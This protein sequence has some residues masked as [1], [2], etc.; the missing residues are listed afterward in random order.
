MF[1]QLRRRFL[2]ISLGFVVALLMPVL[3]WAA[4]SPWKTAA[5]SASKFSLSR[6]AWTVGDGYELL[7]PSLV[8]IPAPS[9][10]V[11][12]TL[13]VTGKLEL[14]ALPDGVSASECNV[15]GDL[16]PTATSG[17]WLP[18]SVYL[19]DRP[20]ASRD[21]PPEAWGTTWPFVGEV[22]LL[23]SSGWVDYS[24]RAFANCYSGGGEEGNLLDGRTLAVSSFTIRVVTVN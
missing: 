1:S 5:V 15:G 13:Y 2:P 20:G 23:P 19:F 11:A 4:S 3:G 8:R 12:R 16:I 6:I 24:L 7:V 14:P 17:E 9:A 10:P 18:Q 21:V 22:S